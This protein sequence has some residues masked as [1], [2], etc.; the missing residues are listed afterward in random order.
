MAHTDLSW[1][2]TRPAEGF[3]ASE[4]QL[5]DRWPIRT[6]M[7]FGYEPNY[8]Y[9]LL[10]FFHGQ[11]DDE[12][13]VLRLA[14]RLSRRN[15]ICISLRGPDRLGLRQDGRAAYGWGQDGQCDGPIEDYVLR[16][17]EQTRRS[18]HVHSERVYLAGVWEGATLAYRLGLSFPERFA[19]IISLNG[20]MPRRGCPLLRLNELRALKV[21]IGH[22]I[23]NSIVPLTLARQDSR[24]LYTAGLSVHLQSYATTNRIHPDMLRDV[25]RWVMGHV[26]GDA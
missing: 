4:V 17:V 11:G 16:A 18:Y 22:G 20:Q 5:A 26:N 12:E 3:Y 23:A 8:P 1:Q 14:P 6:F 25:N 13:Q 19:G 10:V 9:P 21:F 24:L 15:Y 7:P 2:T